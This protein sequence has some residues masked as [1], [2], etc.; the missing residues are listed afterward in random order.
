MFDF[1]KRKNKKK[2]EV[3]DVPVGFAHSGV[4][5]NLKQTVDSGDLMI[6]N[7]EIH[8]TI[9]N[10]ELNIIPVTN[11]K[12]K[13]VTVSKDSELKRIDKTIENIEILPENQ[14]KGD[15]QNYY[16]RM[17]ELKKPRLIRDS[18][19]ISNNVDDYA[20]PANY[21]PIESNLVN[22][23][24][25]EG[26]YNPIGTDDTTLKEANAT[27]FGQDIKVFNGVQA[28]DLGTFICLYIFQKGRKTIDELQKELTSYDPHLLTI[29]VNKLKNDGFLQLW[30]ETGEYY[31]EGELV[32][33][34]EEEKGLKTLEIITKKVWNESNQPIL[35]DKIKEV[36]EKVNE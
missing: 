30:T 13:Q 17:V 14:T 28:N 12:M 34:K 5:P 20:I 31:H 1:L 36:E 27:I 15:I 2:Q 10:E 22:F 32:E 26:F 19:R 3:S 35:E 6:H 8:P 25:G 24:L 33:T 9:T 23:N 11:E 7:S 4:H 29:L 18:G 21:F 16:N